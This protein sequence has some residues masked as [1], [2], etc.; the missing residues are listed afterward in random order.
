MSVIAPDDRSR[1]P[2]EAM[3]ARYNYYRV[4]VAALLYGTATG[5]MAMLAPMLKQMALEPA[6]IGLVLAAVP[7]GNIAGRVGSAWA[8]ERLGARRAL[9]LSASTAAL[10]IAAL[11][12]VICIPVLFISLLA[13]TA[14]AIRGVSYSV[15]NTAGII[16]IRAHAPPDQRVYAVGLFTAM[17]MAPNSL[18]ASNWRTHFTA[19]RDGFLPYFCDLTNAAGLAFSR[20]HNGAGCKSTSETHTLPRTIKRPP[21]VAAPTNHFLFR[22]GLRFLNERIAN[23]FAGCAYSHCLFF[24]ELRHCAD[25]QPARAVAIFPRICSAVDRGLRT[26]SIDRLDV[27]VACQIRPERSCNFRYSLWPRLFASPCNGGM[28]A[29][30]LPE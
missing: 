21:I 11:I 26:D 24:H 23:I 28:V 29:A 30:N 6:A 3:R 25:D 5:Q 18:G 17:F 10:G 15:F 16:A 9:C 1:Q 12:P 27:C 14:A 4:I 22:F 19:L 20:S 2:R 7:L 13:A 8:V